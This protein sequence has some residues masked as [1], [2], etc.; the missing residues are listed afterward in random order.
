MS[1]VFDQISKS[2]DNNFTQTIVGKRQRSNVW[3]YLR[4]TFSQGKPLNVLEL[5]CGT[6]EDALFLAQ[7]GHHVLATDVSHSMLTQARNKVQNAGLENK[8]EFEVLD[9]R[10]PHNLNRQFDLIFSN[11]GGINCLNPTSL[12]NLTSFI[13]RHLG[14]GGHCILVIMPQNTLMEKWY[15]K[16]K[17]TAHVFEARKDPKGLEVRVGKQTVTTFFHNANAIQNNFKKFKTINTMGIGYIPSYFN[18]SRF[19]KIFLRL[20]KVFS[21]IK[22]SPNLSDHYLI[23]L[24]KK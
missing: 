13:S 5:N 4:K 22:L 7:L 21:W 8:L 2:Y 16:S 19:I 15:R 23:H 6:G 1:A 24:V 17:G 9:I 14:S 18:N 3:N 12:K 11:F 20:D 10:E